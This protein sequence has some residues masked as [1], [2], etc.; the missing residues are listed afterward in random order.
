MKPG[1][2]RP[3]LY[4]PSPSPEAMAKR[5]QL[6]GGA[7]PRKTATLLDH[8]EIR[9]LIS[10]AQS[11]AGRHFGWLRR[12]IYG[13]THASAMDPNFVR[14]HDGDHD[15][16]DWQRLEDQYRRVCAAL[17]ECGPAVRETTEQICVYDRCDGLAR[18]LSSNAGAH[19]AVLRRGLDAIVQART[20]D[21]TFAQQA[22]GVRRNS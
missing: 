5:R 7:D 10:H 21:R 22:S 14:D 1:S 11:D 6:A 19:L 16:T 15:K 4:D 12:I 3:S 8:L 18:S 13:R 2:G 17:V 9:H 20:H